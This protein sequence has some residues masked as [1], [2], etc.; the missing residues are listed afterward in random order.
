MAAYVVQRFASGPALSQRPPGLQAKPDATQGKRPLPRQPDADEQS[1]ALQ[2]SIEAAR[3]CGHS[4]D[5]FTQH[6]MESSFGADFSGVRIHTD[7]RADGLSRS[8]SARAFTTGHDVFF[9]RGEYSPGTSS[10]HELLAHELTHVVQQNGAGVRVRLPENDLGHPLE[11]EARQVVKAVTQQDQVNVGSAAGSARTGP[12]ISLPNV[13]VNSTIQ[14]DT[15]QRD[16]TPPKA[17]DVPPKA[18]DAPPKAAD[19]PA[20]TADAPPPKADEVPAA[21]AHDKTPPGQPAAA[22]QVAIDWWIDWQ[23]KETGEPVSSKSNARTGKDAAN[24]K[25][26]VI[27]AAGAG[28][29][30]LYSWV[31]AASSGAVRVATMN[32]AKDKG[33]QVSTDISWQDKRPSAVA[34]VKV[35][36]TAD[37]KKNTGKSQLP[38]KQKAAN[39]AAAAALD[40][41]LETE[42]GLDLLK[43]DML[44]AAQDA[45]GPGGNGYTYSVSVDLKLDRGGKNSR[46]AGPVSYDAASTDDRRTV[47]VLIPTEVQKL[48]GSG[49]VQLENW[50]SQNTADKSFKRDDRSDEKLDSKTSTLINDV[51]TSFESM[52]NSSF[53]NWKKQR[54]TSNLGG[55][56]HVDGSAGGSTAL[57]GE[58]S[59]LT[60]DLGALLSIILVENPLLAFAVKKAIGTGKIGGKGSVDLDAEIQGH[61]GAQAQWTKEDLDQTLTKID[62]HVKNKIATHVRSE[63]QKTVTHKTS[64]SHTAVEAKDQSTEEGSRKKSSSS[65]ETVGV[66]YIIGEPQLQV[67]N[68]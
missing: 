24:G 43:A 34:A 44:K 31:N 48:R 8:L 64:K 36:E 13:G 30:G 1:S 51:A 32:Q 19:V 58:I 65:A 60:I 41:A 3:G 62:S 59:D 15:I 68:G 46:A 25:L 35:N 38:E 29:T 45:V 16:E 7:E 50:S 11:S 33:G 49:S 10:G 55:S 2:R 40:K 42:G 27:P 67:R 37:D 23:N 56:F 12:P 9:R 57:S 52:F 66:K 54:S 18:A 61:V 63:V 4:M 14:R 6:Q 22:D 21:G 39:E 17:A 47:T 53:D 5:H 28:S 26:K 20:K